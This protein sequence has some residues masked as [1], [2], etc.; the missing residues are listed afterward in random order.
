M[1]IH[2]ALD[3][4]DALLRDKTVH[5]KTART[6]I[7]G[8]HFAAGEAVCVTGI[9]GQTG[10]TT[11]EDKTLR[12]DLQGAPCPHCASTRFVLNVPFADLD[13]GAWTEQVVALVAQ[14]W[15]D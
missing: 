9:S 11:P 12:A 6:T 1:A 2:R 10:G 5:L 13:F 14:G 3:A 15:S 7:G 8:M 4:L